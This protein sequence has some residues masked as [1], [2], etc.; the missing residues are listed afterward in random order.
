MNIFSLVLRAANGV[1]PRDSS[2]C[3]LAAA[4]SAGIWIFFANSSSTAHT[5]P[6]FEVSEIQKSYW[7]SRIDGEDLATTRSTCAPRKA[8]TLP[9]PHTAC[10][11]EG[12]DALEPAREEVAG[13]VTD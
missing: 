6:R 7:R 4:F 10:S 2:R 13:M 3:L 5:A 8:L 1:V 11:P 12:T 9:D